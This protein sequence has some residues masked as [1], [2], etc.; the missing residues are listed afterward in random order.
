[1]KN[2]IRNL[3]EDSSIKLEEVRLALSTTSSFLSCALK[4]KWGGGSMSEA[5]LEARPALVNV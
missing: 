5:K 2:Y 3:I 4:K 1:M